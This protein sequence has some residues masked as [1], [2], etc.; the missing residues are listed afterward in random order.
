MFRFAFSDVELV[1]S[2]FSTVIPVPL[3]TTVVAP[4]TKF[5]PASVTGVVVP[6]MPAAAV[7]VA[8]VGAGNGT[9]NWSPAQANATTAAS[10]T[11]GRQMR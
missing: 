11:D 3:T 8:T 10:R 5:V 9:S 2:M 7:I 1:T 4:G 6:W